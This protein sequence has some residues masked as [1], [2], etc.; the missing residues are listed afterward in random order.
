MGMLMEEKVSVSVRDLVEFLMRGGDIDNRFGGFDRALEGSHIHRML[1]KAE[2]GNYRPEVFLSLERDLGDFTLVVEGRADGVIEDERGFMIDEIKSTGMPAELINEDL[3]PAHWAQAMCYGYIFCVKDSLDSIRIRLSYY[4]TESGEIIRFEREMAFCELE[5]FI[6]D[7]IGRYRKWA[8]VR[9]DWKTVRDASIRELAFP[10]P[11]YRKGQRRLAAEVYRTVRDGGMLFSQ[12]PTGIGKTISAIFP[13]VKA[14]GEGHAGK[15]FYLTAKTTTR[16]VAE[17]ACDEMR[18]RGLRLKSVTLTAKDKI[19]FQERRECNPD[20][21]I[22]AK[23]HYDRVNDALFTMLQNEDVFSRDLIESRAREYCL[24]PYELSLDLALWSDCIIAD[25]N[26]VF[27][28][29]AYLRRFF[30]AGRIYDHVFL[31]DE[32]HNLADRAREMFSASLGKSAFYGIYRQLGKKGKLRRTLYRIN[33]EFVAMRK[34]CGESRFLKKR[35][36]YRELEHLL[37]AFAS[38]SEAW[39][40]EHRGSPLEEQ[41]LQLCFDVY[42]FMKIAEFYDERYVTLVNARGDDVI[43]KLCCLDPSRLLGERMKTG[44]AAA[45]FSATLTPLDYFVSLLG[46]D[47]N[48]KRLELPS[49]FPRENLCLVIN[50][51]IS[52]RYRDRENSLVPVAETIARTVSVKRGN[53]IAY[54]PS[55]AYMK[56]VHDVFHGMYPDVRTAVQHSDMDEREREAFLERFDAGNE[57]TLVGFC[58]LGGIYSEGIDLRGDRLIGTV[59]VGVGLPQINMMQDILREY[60]DALN[61]NG[62]AYAYRYPGMNKILQAAGRVI[63]SAG[64]RG[65]V[66]LVD[67][68]YTTPQ[69]LALFPDHWKGH[70]KVSGPDELSRRLA[71]FWSK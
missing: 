21:C 15:I 32:A 61:G 26:Y 10:Y 25:Y 48:S 60:Y 20:A 46:G 3:N 14:L 50:D 19:C 11:E 49:P 62:F 16:Q 13:A 27:D 37:F 24:C 38:E 6:D 39:M 65:V 8:A 67:D 1:Q 54:F 36:P 45:L 7:L 33:R 70:L 44:K 56:A 18:S 41:L 64:D 63:R 68:R 57:E 31:I 43:L 2:G 55:Y 28:P 58:V 69:Y 52:T 23:G 51:R 53:Y 47:E 71:S 12:A 30:A 4:Q 40:K 42:A 17:R 22:Y 66:V 59:I 9:R 35:E 29:Q 34:K 5:A